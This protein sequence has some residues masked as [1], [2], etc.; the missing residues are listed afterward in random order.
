MGNRVSVE[1]CGRMSSLSVASRS[2]R[3][4][5]LAALAAALTA[6]G[7]GGG[8]GD[9]G[10]NPP[11]PPERGTVTATVLDDT[12][13]TP[14]SGATVTVT[15][16]TTTLDETTGADGTATV[17]DVPVGSVT[18][19]ASAPGCSWPIFRPEHPGCHPDG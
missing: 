3:L 10:G 19:T 12:F 7:G 8:G 9:D 4:I 15:I 2:L 11:P 18:A 1:G 14:I 16:G 5:A 6:C 13:S 17:N